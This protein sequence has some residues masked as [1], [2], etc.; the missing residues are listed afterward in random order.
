MTDLEFWPDYGP[1]PLW[2][3][4]GKPVDVPSLGLGDELAAQL[5]DWNAAYA[6]DKVPLEGAG[7]EAWLAEGRRLLGEVRAALGGR[8]RVVVTEPWWGEQPT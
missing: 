3:Q 4:D 2:T 7:D 1:G 8:H 5:T 6:E